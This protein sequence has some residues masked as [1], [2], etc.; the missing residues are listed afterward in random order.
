MK[1]GSKQSPTTP[2]SPFVCTGVTVAH[3]VAMSAPVFVAGLCCTTRTSPSFRDTN[4]RPDP[5][6][7]HARPVPL[8]RLAKLR[9]YSVSVKLA[10]STGVAKSDETLH[11]ET[12][13]VERSG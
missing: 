7:A 5:S 6:G 4:R 10:V 3:G 9:T 1:S 13:A 12:R 11:T 8:P 2:H